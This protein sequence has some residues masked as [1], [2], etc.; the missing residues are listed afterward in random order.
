MT[1]MMAEH[2][3][4]PHLR[5]LT[6]QPI[7]FI[8]VVT[9]DRRCV[10]TCE[11]AHAILREIWSRGPLLDGWSVG[12]YVLMPDHLH[13]FARAAQDGKALAQ[14]VQSWK[15]MSSRRLA[16]ELKLEVPVWQKDYFD[17]FLR[18]PEDYAHKWNYVSENP[19]RRGIVATAADWKW[20]GVIEDL[21]F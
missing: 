1:H 19:V 3:H 10:L 14:W 21:S 11:V 2:L 16:S 9:Y 4:L 8:T 7:V 13:L 20:K 17:R 6:R 12:Q 5:P 15:S 18:S